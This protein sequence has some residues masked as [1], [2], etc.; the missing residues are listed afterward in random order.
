M[1]RRFRKC[2][3]RPLWRAEMRRRPS[4]HSRGPRR[5]RRYG[6][7]LPHAVF[8]GNRLRIADLR[9]AFEKRG[10]RTEIPALSPLPSP[11]QTL[12]PADSGVQRIDVRA[13]SHG[14]VKL[15]NY[16]LLVS[17]SYFQVHRERR[18]IPSMGEGVSVCC[19]S[20]RSRPFQRRR[21]SPLCGYRNRCCS[22]SFPSC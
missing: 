17:T 2:Q 12:R 3:A 6:A 9:A 20:W 21:S 5:G 22:W 7:N 8:R 15:R 1:C 16:S 4:R 14:C 10:M 13:F 18:F 19:R 11:F